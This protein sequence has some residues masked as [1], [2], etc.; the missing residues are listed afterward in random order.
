M[1]DKKGLDSMIIFFQIAF[2]LNQA[3]RGLR[4]RALAREIYWIPAWLP[5]LPNE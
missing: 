5:H 1:R 4:T 2:A 3:D